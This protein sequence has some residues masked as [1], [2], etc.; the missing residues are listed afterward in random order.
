L[1]LPTRLTGGQ[2]ATWPELA[3]DT[4]CTILHHARSQQPACGRYSRTRDRRARNHSRLCEQKA[5]EQVPIPP[6]FLSGAVGHRLFWGGIMSDRLRGAGRYASSNT[7]TSGLPTLIGLIELAGLCGVVFCVG[8]GAGLYLKNSHFWS[9][10]AI[11]ASEDKPQFVDR[12]SKGDRLPATMIN[13]P[14][15]SAG[16]QDGFGML[17]LGGPPNATITIRDANGRLVFELDPLKRATV[18]SKR[19]AR[20]VPP[21]KE[22]SGYVAPKS[23]V[24]PVGDACKPPSC[25]V[26]S[27]TPG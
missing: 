2:V 6:T 26:A 18:V 4:P 19:E 14:T 20:G 9:T 3:I 27:I 15:H 13:P 24:A 25:R 21:S 22:P 5:L 8:A 16:P 1:R 12:S 17:E 10:E 23:V 11:A 7:G